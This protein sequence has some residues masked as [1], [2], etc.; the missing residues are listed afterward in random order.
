M[1]LENGII[2][3]NANFES[4]NPKIDAEFLNIKA[5]GTPPCPYSVVP[6]T[7]C[8]VSLERYSMA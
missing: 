8:A 4:L 2:P 6:L 1:I 5:C 7:R 3:P